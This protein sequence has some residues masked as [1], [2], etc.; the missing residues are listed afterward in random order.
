MSRPRP[1]V[2][3]EILPVVLILGCLIGSW[4]LVVSV[5]RGALRVMASKKD[6]AKP[7][8]KATPAL[9][10][11]PPQPVA[12][13]P[14]PVVAK[15]A[16]P[17]PIPD[18][19]PV[20]PQPPPMD[21]T[22]V[23]LA[24]LAVEES[25]QLVATQAADRRAAELEQSKQN[26]LAEVDRWKRREQ[27]IRAQANMINRKSYELEQEADELAEQRDVLA[28]ERDISKAE[29][30]KAQNRSSFAVLPHRGANGTWRRPIIIE[31]SNGTAKLQPNGPTFQMIE[32][33]TGRGTRSNPLAIATIRS[34]I[35]AQG[36]RAPDG[37]PTIPYIFF[38]VRPDGIRPYYEA[39]SRLEPLGIAFG[40]ELVPQ[41]L[42]IDYP[43][44]DNPAEWD[45]SAP[46]RPLPSFLADNHDSGKGH[47]QGR[48]G[49]APD[50][51]GL[52]T[53]EGPAKGGSGNPEDEFRWP[54][55]GDTPNRG[56][57]L[58]DDATGGIPGGLELPES[59]TRSGSPRGR[60][61]GTPSFTPGMPAPLGETGRG[62]G[63]A[64]SNPDKK[65]SSPGGVSGDEPGEFPAITSNN[66][67]DPGFIPFDAPGGGRGQASSSVTGLADSSS[68]SG[69]GLI[70]PSSPSRGSGRYGRPASA[71]G[72]QGP[73]RELASTVGG[74]SASD[75]SGDIPIGYGPPPSGGDAVGQFP[76]ENSAASGSEVAANG[77]GGGNGG[78][79][80]GGKP[81]SSSGAP[82]NGIP[83]PFNLGSRG[84][85]SGLSGVNL[86]PSLAAILA[87][88][89]KSGEDSDEPQPISEKALAEANAEEYLGKEGDGT[90]EG[91]GSGTGEPGQN[92][93]PR[94]RRGQDDLSP[95]K[96]HVPM[97]IV[98]ACG[99]DGIVIHPGGYHLT[100]KA[101]KEK[102]KE[103][104]VTKT[105]KGVVQLRQ[106]VDPMIRQMPSVRYLIESGGEETYREVRRQTVLSGLNWPSTLQVSDMRL[107]DLYPKG[108]F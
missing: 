22:K 55:E 81:G 97:E 94:S 88:A 38:V 27:A 48:D 21:P 47:V 102:G 78:G 4:F 74:S 60:N 9:P 56:E 79:P 39:R 25:E 33:A 35:R 87:N 50:R 36:Q 46:A 30:A 23:E 65:G 80:P 66:T 90:G 8:A 62:S 13:P 63:L 52:S 92:G 26:A 64:R 45:G 10:P 104:V 3:A 98:V 59:G 15:E 93:S 28:R 71:S 40:Y 85:A 106:Q 77:S 86:P 51:T 16:E 53:G 12:P 70:P 19:A 2:A 7:I 84:N 103:S 14:P 67:D 41:E 20:A 101:L 96:I 6:A 49:F 68:G 69:S 72:S 17:D 54:T 58:A 57:G 44:L 100:T 83:V 43:D 29:L 99:P 37:S 5:H 24:K 107:L 73:N 42:K 11:A 75:G 18:P 61:G 32:L 95:R 76:T 34:L 91:S 82:P 1:G 89:E 105:L 31:C 108:S